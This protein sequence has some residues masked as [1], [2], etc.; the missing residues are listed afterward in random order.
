MSVNL[1]ITDF[2]RISNGDFNAGSITLTSKGRLDKVNNHVG[3]L[4]IFN[5][6]TI[7]AD[8]IFEVKNAFVQA[9]K[10]TGIS[11]AELAK[12]REELGLPK[13][14]GKKDFDL[15]MLEPLT[16]AKTRDILDRYAN[17]INLQAGRTVVS[18]KWA[19]QKSAGDANYTANVALANRINQKTVDTLSTSQRK[20]GA[21]ILK[22]GVNAIPSDVSKLNEFKAL[23][24]QAKEKFAKIFTVM[25]FHG[26]ADVKAIAKDAI[27]KAIAAENGT[28]KGSLEMQ[29][30]TIIENT[31]EFLKTHG[32]EEL[33]SDETEALL[34]QIAKWEDMKPGQMVNF[35]KMVKKD[36]VT[37]IDNCIKGI[38]AADSTDALQFEDDGFCTQLR[39][40]GYRSN[41]QVS[42]TDGENTNTNFYPMQN[43]ENTALNNQIRCVLTDKADLSLVTGLM[44]QATISS[45]MQLYANAPSPE[46][47]SDEPKPLRKMDAAGDHVANGN[48]N[49][50]ETEL[51]MISQPDNKDLLYNLE[52]DTKTNTAKLTITAD[53]ALKPSINLRGGIMLQ[54]GDESDKLYKVAYS[55][56]LNISGLG[57]GNPQLDSVGFAQKLKANA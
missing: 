38:H 50:S 46:D 10:N 47:T 55:L 54:P 57:S 28:D 9:L 24:V 33:T 6:K 49:I 53:Y 36:L 21:Q 30:L 14:E 1:S 20:L 26:G 29:K 52:V 45:I 17:H 42:T 8:T 27:R 56:E 4:S 3:I 15:S 13:G 5:N 43:K 41:V 32:L 35:E 25:L 40:D 34:D 23:S 7:K 39:K 48:P 12:V 2:Q 22:G 16:R 31:N 11:E 51:L 44:N 19:A 37:Y 18:N